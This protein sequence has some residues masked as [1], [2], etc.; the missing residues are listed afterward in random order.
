[1][2]TPPA[3]WSGYL[4]LGN[5]SWGSQHP[6][7]SPNQRLKQAHL[8]E[9]SYAAGSAPVFNNKFVMTARAYYIPTEKRACN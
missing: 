7:D 8:I 6:V 9:Y 4:L 1:M 3:N 2:L 5:A